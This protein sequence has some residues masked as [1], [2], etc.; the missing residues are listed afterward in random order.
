MRVRFCL[1]SII[2]FFI[3]LSSV[4]AR[5][6]KPCTAKDLKGTHKKRFKKKLQ[7]CI[8]IDFKTKKCRKI[9]RRENCRKLEDERLMNKGLAY[10]RDY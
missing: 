3:L 6:K 5:R 10:I 2:L 9:Q 7:S 8:E 4:S 1:L